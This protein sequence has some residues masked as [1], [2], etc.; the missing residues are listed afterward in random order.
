MAW[1]IVDPTQVSLS[2]QVPFDA[3]ADIVLADAVE[4]TYA[5]KENP[6]FADVC[7]GVCHVSSGTYEITYQVKTALKKSYS[8][9]STVRELRSN[10]AIVKDLG[11]KMG[12]DRMPT[13]MID[14]SLRD[15][16]E[17]YAGAAGMG[18]EMLDQLDQVLARF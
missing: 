5:D 1:K 12:L 3:S 4:D 6:L 18:T 9:Y 2:V 16:M 10:A 7:D 8:T 15:I 11:E 17:K 13:Q 14:M